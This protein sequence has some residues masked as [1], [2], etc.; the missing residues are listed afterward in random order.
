MVMGL[1]L[2]SEPPTR[3]VL[4]SDIWFDTLVIV[5]DEDEELLVEVVVNVTGTS[6]TLFHSV[7]AVPF[8]FA[9]AMAVTKVD[10]LLNVY[11]LYELF[12]VVL[13]E[14]LLSGKSLFS[15]KLNRLSFGSISMFCGASISLSSSLEFRRVNM[16]FAELIESVSCPYIILSIGNVTSV[17]IPAG[18]FKYVHEESFASCCMDCLSFTMRVVCITSSVPDKVRAPSYMVSLLSYLNL[19][20][21]SVKSISDITPKPPVDFM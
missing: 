10:M 11:V 15:K 21:K 2:L 9:L 3:R 19:K 1:R 20:N 5:V 17:N 16:T 8:F 14:I 7:E 13:N 12:S 6:T 18:V 4:D